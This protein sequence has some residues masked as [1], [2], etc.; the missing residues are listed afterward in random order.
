[1]LLRM[2]LFTNPSLTRFYRVQGMNRDG[3]LLGPCLWS[4]PILEWSSV[5]FQ[6]TLPT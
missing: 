4:A 1:M 2:L 6:A 5:V 3:N